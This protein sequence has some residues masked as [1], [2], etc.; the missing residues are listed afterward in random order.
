MQ[1]GNTGV[2]AGC[3]WGWICGIGVSDYPASIELRL[4]YGIGVGW[5]RIRGKGNPKRGRSALSGRVIG[6]KKGH[7]ANAYIGLEG[8]VEK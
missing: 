5:P 6:I 4:C 8:V 7:A 2:I 3:P 1:L